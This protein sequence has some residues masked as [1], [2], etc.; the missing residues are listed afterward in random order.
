[1]YNSDTSATQPIVEVTLQGPVGALVQ[2]V[3]ADLWFE[4]RDQGSSGYGVSQL[5]S[6]GTYIVQ[7]PMHD[8]VA[9]SGIYDYSVNL[10]IT[11]RIPQP[12]GTFLT[13]TFAT[14]TSG[15][16]ASYAKTLSRATGH[17]RRALVPPAGPSERDW[18]RPRRPRWQRFSAP[19]PRWTALPGCSPGSARGPSRCPRPPGHAPAGAPRLPGYAAA[20]RW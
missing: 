3:R 7:V 4:G 14:A 20:R 12:D 9:G 18:R 5:S 17:S 16:A 8:S 2:S 10:T 13:Q 11:V 1:V 6:T 15:R 19:E